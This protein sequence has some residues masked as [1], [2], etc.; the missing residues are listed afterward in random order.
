MAIDR[1]L[2]RWYE[3]VSC[4]AMASDIPLVSY[5]AMD[6][7]KNTTLNYKLFGQIRKTWRTFLK[8]CFQPKIS[9][10]C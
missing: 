3:I 7:E 4:E 1:L 9:L 6:W 5:I 2:G 10:N 8:N